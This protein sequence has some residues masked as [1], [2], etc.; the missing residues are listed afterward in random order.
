MAFSKYSSTQLSLYCHSIDEA[1]WGFKFSPFKERIATRVRLISATSRQH[2]DRR[3]ATLAKLGLSHD[4]L[5]ETLPR[6]KSRVKRSERNYD[7]ELP[8]TKPGMHLSPP[9]GQGMR[10]AGGPSGI[11]PR[12]HYVEVVVIDAQR[13]Y[14]RFVSGGMV[15]GVFLHENRFR[16][17]TIEGN[18]TTGV[19][20]AVWVPGAGPIK[21]KPVRVDET[22]EYCV[23]KSRSAKTRDVDLAIKMR[24]HMIKFKNHRLECE[25]EPQGKL[26]V[27]AG[28]AVGVTIVG[29]AVE[30]IKFFRESYAKL[31]TGIDGRIKTTVHSMKTAI[32][33]LATIVVLYLIKKHYSVKVALAVFTALLAFDVGP[34]RTMTTLLVGKY[35]GLTIDHFAYAAFE[36]RRAYMTVDF[37][38]E[39][40]CACRVGLPVGCLDEE[41]EKA[42]KKQKVPLNTVFFEN[43]EFARKLKE[44][45][46]E[47]DAAAARGRVGPIEETFLFLSRAQQRCFHDF[48]AHGNL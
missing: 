27:A 28:V 23:H 4:L 22:L 37:A 39:H 36:N 9:R 33:V 47:Y 44:F 41:W 34:T 10:R 30:K 3:E 13:V 42:V 45:V 43:R 24:R 20:S 26:A 15:S 18:T 46:K 1:F 5:V 31:I 19:C 35:L 2:I 14:A 12:G 6:E 29:W 32:T 25:L 7:Y 17:L 21:G 8:P 40:E 48:C 38:L 11:M 16:G